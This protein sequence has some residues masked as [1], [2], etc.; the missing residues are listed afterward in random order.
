MSTEI[1]LLTS[2]LGGSI[3]IGVIIFL[4]LNT[5]FNSLN[6]KVDKLLNTT[7]ELNHTLRK[8]QELMESSKPI[9]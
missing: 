2:V 4:S 9:I 8:I 1:V 5:F 7:E 6:N 3:I